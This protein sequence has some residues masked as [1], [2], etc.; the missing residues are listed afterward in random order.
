MCS[1]IFSVILAVGFSQ[2]ASVWIRLGDLLTG[3]VA[4]FAVECLIVVAVVLVYRSLD[5]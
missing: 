1:I 3:R 5:S 2:W 4:E